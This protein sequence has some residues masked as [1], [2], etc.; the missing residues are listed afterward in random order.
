MPAK[1]RWSFRSDYGKLATVGQDMPLQVSGFGV[2]P[3]VNQ[4]DAM[5]LFHSTAL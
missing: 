5:L 1:K 2:G 3:Q 4:P